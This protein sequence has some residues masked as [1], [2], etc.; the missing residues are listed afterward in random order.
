VTTAS[1]A[2]EVQVRGI[3]PER[4]VLSTALDPYMPLKA[5]AAYSGMSVR[6]LRDCLVDPAHPLPHYRYGGKILVRR[7][8]FDA[9]LAVYRQAGRADVD[10][11]V[12]EVLRDLGGS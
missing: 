1:T 3:L 12:D 5:L 4:I 8:E 7:S 2:A 6:L 9:W 11:V 10:R